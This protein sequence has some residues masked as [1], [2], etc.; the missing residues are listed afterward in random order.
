MTYF[1][2]EPIKKDRTDDESSEEEEGNR[3]VKQMICDSNFIAE[4]NN[5]IDPL[6]MDGLEP[7]PATANQPHSIKR[8]FVWRSEQ[9][10]D[11]F[12]FTFASLRLSL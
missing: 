8:P 7:D 11:T 6:A 9:V 5:A 10:Y 3:A 2:C 12:L 4:D 1:K